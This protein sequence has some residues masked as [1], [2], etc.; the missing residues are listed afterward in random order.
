MYN[1]YYIMVTDVS[2]NHFVVPI[3]LKSS[4]ACTKG[5]VFSLLLYPQTVLTA[6]THVDSNISVESTH[7]KCSST[8][9]VQQSHL[10][11]SYR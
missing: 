9:S 4:V 5:L 8:E 1:Y 10:A 3:L 6:L 11:K 2:Q 7:A